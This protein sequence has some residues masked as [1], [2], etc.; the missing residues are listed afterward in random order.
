MM[1]VK[2]TTT[3]FSFYQTI[4]HDNDSVNARSGANVCEAKELLDWFYVIRK[5][6]APDDCGKTIHTLRGMFA[7]E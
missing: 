2:Q 4:V 5:S 3:P 6:V 1:S 7:I